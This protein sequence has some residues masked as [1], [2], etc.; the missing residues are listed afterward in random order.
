MTGIE[1]LRELAKGMHNHRV[2][3]WQLTDDAYEERFGVT[4]HGPTIKNF[5]SDIADQIEREAR[6]PFSRV[7][8]LAVVSDMES[9]VSDEGGSFGALVARW[10]RELRGATLSRRES[11]AVAD[12][13]VSAYDLLPQEDR[14]AIA[15]VRDHGGLDAVKKLLDWVVGHCSTRQQLDFD[16]WLSGRVMHELG[17]DED[18]AGRDEVE[19]R[20]R[21]RLMPE[22]M[23]WLVEAWPRFE[24]DAPV[25]L[26]DD[27]ERYGEESG[28]SAVTMYADG[29]FAL[30]CRAYSRGERVKRPTPK[31]LDADGVECHVG[32]HG[33]WLDQPGVEVIIKHIDPREMS[34]LTVYD[35]HGRGNTIGAEEFTHRAP[36]IA[37][38]GE[39]LLKDETVWSVESGTRY[40]VEKITDELIPVKCRSEMGSTVSLHPSQLTH[41]RPESWG[42]LE[43]DARSIARDIAWNLGNWSPSDFEDVGDDVQARVVD[44]VRRAKKL[45]GVSE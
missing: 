9:R 20:L 5:L 24:D 43:K 7:R 31:V 3:V 1:R 22:G 30:N 36:V 4:K 29:S 19:R 28:A 12:V 38:N 26:L 44:L 10:A 39:P 34:Q 27:F 35:V 23:E 42:Q 2:T 37:A 11:D 8:V 17:F 14:E 41:E 33:Y 32:D 25:K 16:F 21:D 40:T 6:A 18:M 13:S 15:W 45:A